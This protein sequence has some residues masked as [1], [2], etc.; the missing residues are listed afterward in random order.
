MMMT[1]LHLLIKTAIRNR[2]RVPARVTIKSGTTTTRNT[3]AANSLMVDAAVTAITTTANTSARSDVENV[4][5]Y[6]S[7]N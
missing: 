6:Q 3:N 1:Q 2:T 7:I 4:S 5:D